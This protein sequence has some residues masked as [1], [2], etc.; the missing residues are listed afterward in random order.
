M[1]IIIPLGGKG[2]RFQ[3]NGYSLPK[4]LIK[5]FEKEMIFYVL[6]NIKIQNDDEIYIIYYNLESYN[7]ENVILSK[8]PNV[9][10]I[11]LS[12]QTK[13]ASETLLIGIEQIMKMS[14]HKKCLTMDCDT[15]YTENILDMYRNENDNAVFYTINTEIKPLYSY[16]DLDENKTITNIIEKVKISDNANT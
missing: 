12:K 13:G 4:P 9:K 6:D 3:K 8:Y 5:V 10:F 7:F 11:K 16:I 14:K 15:F 1:N 2:E